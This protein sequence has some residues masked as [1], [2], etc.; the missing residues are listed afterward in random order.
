LVGVVFL[1]N[2]IESR[3][4]VGEHF[5]PDLDVLNHFLDMRGAHNLKPSNNQL[6]LE[7]RDC[8]LRF[9]DDILD[10]LQ[11]GQETQFFAFLVEEHA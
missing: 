5:L 11:F 6:Q 10:N 7:V 4:Q 1:I 8:L 2:H 3:N 9:V